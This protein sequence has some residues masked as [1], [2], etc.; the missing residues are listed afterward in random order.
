MNYY[1]HDDNTGGFN[2]DANATSV[3]M[4]GTLTA[5]SSSPQ[6]LFVNITYICSNA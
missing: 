5:S 2:I 6:Y 3:S 1:G 4:F